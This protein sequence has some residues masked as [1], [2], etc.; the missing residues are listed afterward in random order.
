MLLGCDF[1]SVVGERDATEHGSVSL[2]VWV[3]NLCFNENLLLPMK[4]LRL[5]GMLGKTSRLC[6]ELLRKFGEAELVSHIDGFVTRLAPTWPGSR[7]PVNSESALFIY[8]TA[9]NEAICYRC[10]R[11]AHLFD[12]MCGCLFCS[13]C[14]SVDLSVSWPM[15]FH[16]D[17]H[18]RLL[19]LV[20]YIMIIR[21]TAYKQIRPGAWSGQLFISHNQTAL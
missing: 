4:R 9:K 10:W 6:R 17:Q 7:A 19:W 20:A 21:C 12:W 1:M 16:W 2:C 8:A 14:A 13:T 15:S 18:G 3:H 11:L 5:L